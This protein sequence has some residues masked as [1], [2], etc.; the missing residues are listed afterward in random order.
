MLAPW[1][2]DE[3]KSV[4][5]NDKRLSDR[6]RRILSDLGDRPTASIPAACGGHAEMTAA[7]RFF[8]NE[9]VTYKKILEP[10]YARTLERMSAQPIVLLVQDT[11]EIDVTRPHQQV[12]GAGALDTAARRGIFLHP[13]EAFTPDGTPLGAV[14]SKAWVREDPIQQTRSEKDRRNYHTPIEEKESIRW[15]EGLRA[16]RAAAEQLSHTQCVCIADSEGDIFDLFVEPRGDGQLHWLV[17]GC[18]DRAL[19]DA[20][21]KKEVAPENPAEN[22]NTEQRRLQETVLA[23]PVLFTKP[24]SVRGRDMKISCDTHGRRQPRESRQTEVEVRATTV[25]L[26]PP[27]R[28]DRQ[29]PAVT[30]NVVL[31]REIDPPKGDVAVEWLLVTTLPIDT[32]DQVRAIVQYYAARFLIEVYFRT[33]KS[34]CRVEERMF[35]HIDRLLPCVAVYLIVAWRTLLVCRLS[36]NCPDLDCEAIFDPSEWKSVWMTVKHRPLPAKPPRLIE[37][38]KLV[39]QLGGYVNRPNRKD[40]PGP[41]T[42]WLGLQR[43]RDLAWAWTTF[44]PGASKADQPEPLLV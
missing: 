37:M 23:T 41:Q 8:D 7:Y 24:I 2:T 32:M 25:A 16:A 30:V 31:V 43:M 14:W 15:V 12:A 5:L 13:L 29:L 34:G 20:G 38:I 42:V 21:E 11:T 39:A 4:D 26:R 35:E 27:Y 3:M 33:L 9:E 10:H 1:V 19:E 22:D 36:R 44:G 40:P 6:L 18:R 17:R 28:R